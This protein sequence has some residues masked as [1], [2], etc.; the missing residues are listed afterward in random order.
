MKLLFSELDQLDEM[1]SIIVEQ[2]I[3]NNDMLPEVTLHKMYKKDYL[4]FA[5]RFDPDTRNYKLNMTF[6]YFNTINESSEL[7]NT[8]KIFS[9]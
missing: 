8:L 4:N 6:A 1:D 3:Y 5:H 2:T 9:C 7:I